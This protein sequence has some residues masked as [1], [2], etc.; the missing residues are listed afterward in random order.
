MK[1]WLLAAIMA[2]AISLILNGEVVTFAIAVNLAIW[3]LLGAG[4]WRLGKYILARRGR[5]EGR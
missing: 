3:G 2:L 1:Y 5:K 4:L